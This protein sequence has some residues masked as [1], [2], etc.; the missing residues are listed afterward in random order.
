MGIGA[1]R[2]GLLSVDKSDE[3]DGRITGVDL[4]SQNVQRGLVVRLKVVLQDRMH[5][6]VQQ[7][8]PHCQAVSAQVR[9][10]GADEHIGACLH[11]VLWPRRG[12]GERN[13]L[14]TGWKVAGRAEKATG[15]LAPDS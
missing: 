6:L 14:S 15:I 11:G 4:A 12:M 13:N 1:A 10:G 2:G 7:G 5:T 3:A 9:R 8:I